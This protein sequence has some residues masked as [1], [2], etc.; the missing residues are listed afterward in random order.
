[1]GTSPYFNF[2][3]LI[4]LLA[5]LA[6]S[7]PFAVR[8]AENMGIDRSFSIFVTLAA[9]IVALAFVVVRNR[10]KHKERIVARIK[11]I[12]LQI[13]ANPSE[14]ASYSYQSDHL[15]DLYLTLGQHKEALSTFESYLELMTSSSSTASKNTASKDKASDEDAEHQ[16]EKER[17]ILAIKRLK[18]E[19]TQ[20][21]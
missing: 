3:S 13:E 15:A 8:L 17:V 14:K 12:Q 20:D 19:L 9:A 7:L 2:A 6:F 10:L 21:T 5:A 1:M 16:K 18:Q 4:A 11:Q